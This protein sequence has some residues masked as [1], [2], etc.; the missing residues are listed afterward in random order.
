MV[1][2]TAAR[3]RTLE[4]AEDVRHVGLDRLGREMQVG[5]DAA[6]GVAVGEQLG[7][8]ALAVGERADAG[9][10]SP[11][12]RALAGDAAAEPAQL[13]RGLVVEA[14][15]AGVGEGLA[16]RRVSATVASRWWPPAASAWPAS[17]CARAA[18]SR[19]PTRCASRAAIRAARVAPA[20]SPA[21]SR[22]AARARSASL[23]R[24]GRPRPEA[25]ISAW[26]A[27]RSAS[28]KRPAASSARVRTSYQRV[29]NARSTNCSSGSSSLRQAS[30]SPAS[31][32]A[33]AR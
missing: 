29:W 20:L 28:V 6:V 15:R 19:L 7:D 12:A 17:S 4:L 23:V 5:G 21:A 31:R 22:T 3:E 14:A 9:L 1:A 11:A 32:C 27:W 30:W 18:S 2:A 8:L 16:A 24:A 26:A 10:G 33:S 25:A 13:A